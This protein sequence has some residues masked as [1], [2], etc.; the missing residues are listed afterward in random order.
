MTSYSRQMQTEKS[1]SHSRIYS[2]CRCRRQENKELIKT[3]QSLASISGVTTQALTLQGNAITEL[4][5]ATQA[6]L[7]EF[8]DASKAQ[9][10]G[11][12][13]ASLWEAI[14]GNENDQRPI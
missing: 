5:E 7:R 1:K 13:V 14:I 4:G 2:H 3:Q 6:A 12:N 8:S 11:N 10:E 9:K